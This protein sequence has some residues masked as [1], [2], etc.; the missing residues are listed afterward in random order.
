VYKVLGINLQLLYYTSS[1]EANT[2]FAKYIISAKIDSNTLWEDPNLGNSLSTSTFYHI[3]V[4]RDRFSSII[5]RTANR[6]I[7]TK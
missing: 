4:T 1:E 7:V 2:I 3:I 5:K 6:L